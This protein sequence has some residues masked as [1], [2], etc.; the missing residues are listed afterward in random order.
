MKTTILRKKSEIPSDILTKPE[1]VA[2]S[3][4][5]LV[6]K[7]SGQRVSVL[8]YDNG[9]DV[10]LIACQRFF[11]IPFY[12][13]RERAMPK[14]ALEESFII[15]LVTVLNPENLPYEIEKDEEV[16]LIYDGWDF[17]RYPNMEDATTN[18]EEV[19][20]NYTGAKIEDFVV[21]VGK[22]MHSRVRQAALRR[23]RQMEEEER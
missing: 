9:T 2:I 21:L 18:I 22:E 7:Y 3:T 16:F 11:D 13:V 20:Q 1:N 14:D 17:T 8:L 4:E 12:A 6:L 10:S 19:L 5:D 23:I 15:I